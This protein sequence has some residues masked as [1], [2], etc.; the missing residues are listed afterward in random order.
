MY[1]CTKE[2]KKPLLS[3]L[4]A[5]KN[6]ALGLGC[7]DKMLFFCFARDRNFIIAAEISFQSAAL[8]FWHP[9]H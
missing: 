1:E 6:A 9:Q 8:M 3:F 5:A 2:E 7:V 4:P